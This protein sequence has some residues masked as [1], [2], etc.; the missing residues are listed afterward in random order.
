MPALFIGHGSPMNAIETNPFTESLNLLGK[1]FIPKPKAILVV[2]AHWLAKGSY[3]FTDSF[4]E[5]IYDFYGFP[6]ALFDVKYPAAGSPEFAGMTI[7][8][9]S[10]I[11]ENNSWGIDHG[12]WTV[13]KHMFPAADI[14]VFQLSIDMSKPLSYHSNLAKSLLPLRNQGVLIL[15]SGNIVHNLRYVYAQNAPYDWAIEFDEWVKNKIDI[16]DFDSLINFEKQGTAA[17]LSVPTMDHYIP[18]I[19]A[20]ALAEESE[21]IAYTYEGI[22]TSLSMRCLKIG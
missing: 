18:L 15:G 7:A 14:P 1:S 4:P 3:V 9:S 5:Q 6:Q 22:E 16:R 12:S 19:Y 17:R 2:S 11:K 10:E 8:L 21:D 13:L 20:L